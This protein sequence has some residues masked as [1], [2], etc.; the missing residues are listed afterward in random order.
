MA[1]RPQP[2]RS[3]LMAMMP[4]TSPPSP[5][6]LPYE[7]H[8]GVSV[9]PNLRDCRLLECH[10]THFL[11]IIRRHQRSRTAGRAT[12]SGAAAPPPAPTGR[13]CSGRA[14]VHGAAHF[15]GVQKTLRR[16]AT[17]GFST[18]TRGRVAFCSTY[19]A[20]RIFQSSSNAIKYCT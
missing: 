11:T 17:S 6:W 4:A 16:K 10:V 19:F 8:D 20:R 1:P 3:L 13:T 12:A 2:Q 9:T 5:S 7:V 15:S 18:T 14:A